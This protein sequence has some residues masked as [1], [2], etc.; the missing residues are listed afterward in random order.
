MCSKEQLQSVI[1]DV[2]AGVRAA[3]GDRLHSLILYGSY[4]RGDYDEESDVDF[5]VLAN[6]K[7]TEL[8]KYRSPIYKVASRASLKNDVE[9]SIVLMDTSTVNQWL[10]TVPYYQNVM[11]EGIKIYGQ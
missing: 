1:D 11:R 6:V 8:I 10:D 5:A 9:V 3:L 7:D 2:R 4:A